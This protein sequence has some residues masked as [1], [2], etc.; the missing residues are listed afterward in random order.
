MRCPLFLPAAAL[1]VSLGLNGSLSTPVL[2]ANPPQSAAATSKPVL[3]TIPGPLRPFLR[4]AGISQ[5]VTAPDVLTMLTFNVN[6]HGYEGWQEKGRPTEFLALLQR[7]IQQARELTALAGADGVIRVSGCQDATPLLKVLGYRVRRECGTANAALITAEPD[8]AFLTIDSGFPLAELEATLQAGPPFA[9]EFH[10]TK[11]PAL[12]V[13]SDW[14]ILAHSKDSSNAELLDTL[15]ENP[16]ISRLYFGMSRMDPDT[17]DLLRRSPG[18]ERLLPYGPALSFYGGQLAIRSG[19]VIIPGGPSAEP[20]WKELVGASPNSPGDF[21]AHLLSRDRGWMVAYFDALS[22][23]NQEQQQRFVEARRLRRFYEAFRGPDLNADAARPIFRPAPGVLLLTT[24]TQWTSNGDPWIPGDYSVWQEILS[25]KRDSKFVRGLMKRNK[26]TA[27]DAEQ[28]LEAM[29]A[30]SRTP[31]EIMPVQ[32]YLMLSAL[33]SRRP[34]DKRLNPD[35]VRLMAGNFSRLSAQYRMFLEFPELSDSTIRDFVA[36]TNSLDAISDHTLRGNA[37]GIFEANLGLWQILARQGQIQHSDLNDSLEAVIA[38]FSRISSSGQ[39]FNAGRS[40]LGGLLRSATGV[41]NHSQDEIIDLL[42]GPRQSTSDGERMHREL[43]ERMN[44]VIASQRLVSLDTLLALGRGLDQVQRGAATA[45]SLQPL[46]EQLTA[47]EMPKPIFTSGERAEWASGVYNNR[48]TELEMHTPFA[49]ILE[50]TPSASQLEVARGELA[51]FLRD[52]LVGLNYAYY[53]P[54]G[55]QVMRHN[56]LFVRSHDFAAETVTGYDRVW[57]AAELF[58]EG[59][60]AGGGAHMVGS[61][62]DLPYVLAEVEQDFISPKNVQALIW[63]AMVPGLLVSATLPRWWDVSRDELHAVGLYQRAGEELLTASTGDAELRAKV[64][65]ILGDRLEPRTIVKVD[66][67]LQASD[68]AA[69]KSYLSAA[70]YFYLAAV[71]R[72]RYHDEADA[73][74]PSSRELGT[75]SRNSPEA[76]NLERLSKNFGVPHPVLAQNY[77]PELLNLRPFPP[78]EGEASRLQ[79]ETWEAS[80]LYWARLA[81]EMGYSPVMLTQLVPQLTQ[82]MVEHIFATDLEDWPALVR[83]VRETGEDFQQ[84]RLASISATNT[85]RAAQ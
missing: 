63:R 37:M 41:P 38:S 65:E 31:G 16:T 47:F 10:S 13:P 22:R 18:L 79:A 23:V 45:A 34:A 50:S 8:R 85:E 64:S 25:K 52:S 35:T 44:T 75:L 30:L 70:D 73:Y 11:V 57:Q 59:S 60:P 69:A 3:V 42:A 29:F 7:Y 28:L 54:P 19:R 55:A 43:A 51:P 6:A 15:L 71:F 49:K 27:A 48:H 17:A 72:H 56:P 67:A 39:L 4:M 53:E 36:T 9:Y 1:V 82:R 80:N 12:F 62:A 33:D 26:G 76:V 20:A 83:A 58:G 81:D 5:K 66:S 40:S 74:G 21:L 78:F 32:E 84:G 68:A 24:R 77:E 61:L 2:A 46:A 14:T